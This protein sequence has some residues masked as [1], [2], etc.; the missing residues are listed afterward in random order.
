VPPVT[1]HPIEAESYRILG[2]RLDLTAWPV[3][4]R[5]VVARV[6]HATADLD[7]AASLVVDE[8]AVSAGVAALRGEAVVVADGE[9]TRAGITG[10]PA[11]CYL[12]EVAPE[13]ADGLTRSAAAMR[14][15]AV[16]HPEGA[17]FTIGS[18]PTALV[19]LIRLAEV[20]SVRPAL[21]VG[22]PVGFVGAAEAKE[23]LRRSGLPAISNTGEKGG[24]AAAAA[25][26]NAL[27]RMAT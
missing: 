17:V 15:A 1:V 13:P 18:A 16:R 19:E 10:T 14:L 12:A 24:S 26:V 11:V 20:G 8:A 21:V 5:E 4:P 22:L 27:V 3:G 7:F 25:A 23:A 9:M 2:S 6:V